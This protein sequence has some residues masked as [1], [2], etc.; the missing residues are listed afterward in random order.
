MQGKIYYYFIHSNPYH[1]YNFFNWNI[2]L[3]YL[4]HEPKISYMKPVALL[5]MLFL[6]TA[7][8]S[9]Q[10]TLLPQ[11][12]FEGSKTSVQQN[13]LPSFSPLGQES[14]LKA[15]LRLD[16]RFKGGH[17][18]FVGV[19]SSPAVVAVNFMDPSNVANT[20][21]AAAGSLQWRLEGGYQYSSK[22]IYFKK[23]SSKNE[24]SKA[25]AQKTEVRKS[26]GSSSYGRCGSQKTMTR[27]K[28]NK[29]LNMRLQPSAG[30]AYIPSVKEDLATEGNGYQYNAGNWKTAVVSGLGFEFGRG[31]QRLLTLGVY[32]TKGLGNLGTKTL[33]TAENGKTSITNFT[34][35][36]SSWTMTIGVPFS[37]TKAKKEPVV[38]TVEPEEKQYYRT[39]SRCGSYRMGSVKE[40]RKL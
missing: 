8:A 28:P 11:V 21:K 31:A 38:K 35:K 16:Y 12:G 30:V 22:P 14:A 26:C 13:N 2:N 4:S 15:A 25:T 32:Y 40:V 34:S 1:S 23:S 9:A 6:L 18:P 36:A 3:T 7:T 20:Y 27:V 5:S 37:L 24:A 17:G 39:K 19:A 29:S 33:T 10:F